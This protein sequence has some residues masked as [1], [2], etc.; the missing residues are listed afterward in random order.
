MRT[1][2]YFIGALVTALF[3]TVGGCAN[4]PEP[5]YTQQTVESELAVP[6]LGNIEYHTSLLADELFARVRADRDFRYAVVNFVPVDSLKFDDDHQHPLMLLGHQ[7]SEGLVTEASRRGFITQDYKIT[8]DILIT[9][10]AEYAIS[11]D[12]SRLSPLQ[13]VDFYI[14]GT[15]TTQQEGAIVNARIVHVESKDVVASATKFFPAQLFW[16]RERVTTRGGLIYR[17]DT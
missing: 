10:T 1:K 7:L 12:V 13:N 15:I 6:A 9:N 16:Q 5:E 3:A 11:R 4:T 14:A 2:Q 8:N 17:T